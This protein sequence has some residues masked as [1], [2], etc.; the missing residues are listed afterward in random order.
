MDWS[1]KDGWMMDLNPGNTS[2][3]ERI[4]ID[5]L[6]RRNLLTVA[7]NTP[8]SNVCS[9]GGSSWLYYLDLKTGHFYPTIADGQAGTLI[10]TNSLV[11]NLA[12]VKLEKFRVTQFGTQSGDTQILRAPAIGLAIRRISWRELA[13]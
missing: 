5:M 2:P 10:S 11:T 4:N 13:N 8:D 9:G 3:G 1:T 7:S 6:R 12:S